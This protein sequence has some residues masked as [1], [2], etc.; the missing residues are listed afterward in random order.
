VRRALLLFW[1]LLALAGILSPLE[2]RAG[3]G[4]P[5]D[6]TRSHG[7]RV[8]CATRTGSDRELTLPALP[9]HT[10]STGPQGAPALRA[11]PQ[12]F[13]ARRR[14]RML[15]VPVFEMSSSNFPNGDV[16]F[17]NLRG[18]G[19]GRA[20]PSLP[21]SP[22]EVPTGADLQKKIDAT[23]QTQEDVSE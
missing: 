22:Y 19:F 7:K 10:L 8:D 16:S 5:M 4:K 18:G 20:P 21:P 15:A 6:C 17:A 9:A 23:P 13:H 11:C 14:G 2:A 3:R 12:V 1:A